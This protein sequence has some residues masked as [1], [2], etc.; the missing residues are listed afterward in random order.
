MRV[1]NCQPMACL[2]YLAV[3]SSRPISG[4][5]CSELYQSQ[6]P[7]QDQQYSHGSWLTD[8]ETG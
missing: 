7:D 3:P 5:H 8:R 4:G 6:A 2:F 1:T